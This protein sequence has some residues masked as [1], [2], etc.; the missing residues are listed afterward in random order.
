VTDNNGCTAEDTVNLSILPLPEDFDIGDDTALCDGYSVLLDAGAGYDLYMWQDG[1][2]TQTYLAADS[3]IYS[4]S[5]SGACG[6]ATDSIHLTLTPLPVFTVGADRNICSGENVLLDPGVFSGYLWQDNS[7][8][9]TYTASSTGHYSVTVTDSN[10]CMADDAMFLIVQYMP[11]FDLGSGGDLCVTTKFL[12]DAGSGVGIQS[13]IW[14]D[15]S[16]LQT[17]MVTQEGTYSVTVSNSCGSVSDSV[18]FPPCPDCI[19]DIPNA[20]TPNGDGNNDELRIMGNGFTRVHLMIYNR[21]GEEVFET[22]DAGQGWNGEFNGKIQP[23]EVYYY[24]MDAD[25]L[26]GQ[27]IVKKGDITLLK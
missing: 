3:G 19:I 5:V 12:L 11:T 20:F 27:R 17:Y 13:Y 2:T 25:C 14:Q 16:N 22:L 9:Q 21:Y 15:G 1:A 18:Y 26:N 10:G 8:G 23:N 7:T 6:I 24:Y 4:V